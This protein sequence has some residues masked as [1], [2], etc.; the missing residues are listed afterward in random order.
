MTLYDNRIYSN[1]IS[2]IDTNFCFVD[3]KNRTEIISFRNYH[4]LN[5]IFEAFDESA[6]LR[7]RCNNASEKIDKFCLTLKNKNTQQY[8]R[9]QGKSI[10]NQKNTIIGL[11]LIFE[12][13][14]E[15]VIINT[16]TQLQTKSIIASNQHYNEMLDSLPYLTWV[17]NNNGKLI[18]A[19]KAYRNIFDNKSIILNTDP[20][21]KH[22]NIHGKNKVLLMSKI[23]NTNVNYAHD[24][25]E[26]S[27]IRD[28]IKILYETQKSIISHINIPVAFYDKCQML[29][30]YN[31][32]FVKLWQID[33]KWLN[34]SPSYS[35][36]QQKLL[37]EKK[38]SEYNTSEVFR[39]TNKP[40]RSTISLQ[41]GEYIHIKIIP[42][43][44]CSLFFIYEYIVK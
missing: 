27:N 41:N 44:D 39:D 36:I 24:A 9:C 26:L 1:I 19:N 37:K 5:E 16:K 25:T 23:N 11:L 15:L 42:S 31:N 35:D 7:K 3:I 2:I 34:N 29:K 6:K 4:S 38:I 14:S 17:H 30:L 20:M 43:I 10:V 22:V 28:E 40:Y 33:K 18:Y 32:A 13:I 8:I 12:D 21:Y